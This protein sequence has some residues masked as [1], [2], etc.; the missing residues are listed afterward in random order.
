VIDQ[1]FGYPVIDGAV[2]VP[3][4]TV[5]FKSDQF[6]ANGKWRYRVSHGGVRVTD[7][8]PNEPID[9]D[10][11]FT[12]VKAHDLL[13]PVGAAGRVVFELAG[14][15]TRTLDVI[16]TNPAAASRD[17][18]NSNTLPIVLAVAGLGTIL[19]GVGLWWRQ[20]R[21]VQVPAS[22]GTWQPPEGREAL[23]SAIATLDDAYDAGHVTD[24]VYEERR[25]ILT[26]RLLPL[27]DEDKES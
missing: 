23:L 6:D 7:L 9:P 3:N 15:P 27:L 25:A 26:E 2:L 17:S 18:G 4:D 10:K 12:L 14:R 24:E 13:K 19:L 21:I 1:A 11:D 22:E 5:E 8:Q 20:R 16:A